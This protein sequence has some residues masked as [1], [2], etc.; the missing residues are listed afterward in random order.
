M[1]RGGVPRISI[2]NTTLKHGKSIYRQNGCTPRR[3]LVGLVV[4]YHVMS[5]VSCYVYGNSF[6]DSSFDCRHTQP[7][8]S[9]ETTIHGTSG[10]RENNISHKY[11]LILRHYKYGYARPPFCDFY[12]RQ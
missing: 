6:K 7:T 1:S 5:M 9:I 2:R 10:I 4:G 3:F 8:P 11:L 12:H